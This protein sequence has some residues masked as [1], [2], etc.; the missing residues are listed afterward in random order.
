MAVARLEVDSRLAEFAEDDA[1]VLTVRLAADGNQGLDIAAVIVNE[2]IR[3]FGTQ[4]CIRN[5]I[6]YIVAHF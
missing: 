2:L 4:A 1:D 6:V 3:V 5:E